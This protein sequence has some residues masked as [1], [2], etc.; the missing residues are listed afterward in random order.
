M[1]GRFLLPPD[2]EVLARAIRREVKRAVEE[3][4]SECATLALLLH[5]ADE[6][7]GECV[8]TRKDIGEQIAAAIRARGSK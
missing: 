1:A 3:E 7:R 5:A 8:G 6:C 2:D 4:R